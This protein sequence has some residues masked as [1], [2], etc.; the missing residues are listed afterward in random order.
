MTTMQRTDTNEW[1]L[2]RQYAQEGSQTAFRAIVD[3]YAALVYSTCL[4]ELG[5]R[6]VAEDA[7]QATF[8]VLATKATRLRPSGPLSAWLFSTARLVS[9]N[10]RRRE[11]AHQ[12]R[13]QAAMDDF[14]SNR[15]NEIPGGD[16]AWASIADN[17]HDA[18]DKLGTADR[19]ALLLRFFEQLS[20]RETADMLGVSEDA[21]KKRVSRALDKLRVRLTGRQVTVPV[22]VL[23]AL[24][25]ERAVN[26]APPT[27]MNALHAISYPTTLPPIGYSLPVNAHDYAQGAL[28]AMR[29]GTQKTAVTIA[30]ISAAALLTTGA[31]IYGFSHI[32]HGSRVYADVP[33]PPAGW[34][35]RCRHTAGKTYVYQMKQTVD[36]VTTLPSGQKTPSKLDE[37]MTF[38]NAVQ[39]VDPATGDATIRMSLSLDSITSGGRSVTLPPSTLAAITKPA[40]LHITPLGK[41][42]GAEGDSA[43]SVLAS[44]AGTESFPVKPVK[45]SD[46]WTSTMSITGSTYSVDSTLVRV[47]E[48]DGRKVAVVDMTLT[49]ISQTA[50]E[51][52]LQSQMGFDSAT[53]E[54]QYDI[55]N[56][57]QLVLHT[58]AV[59][60][61][62]TPTPQ[63]PAHTTAMTDQTSTL[64]SS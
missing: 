61:I 54:G 5:D 36:L 50:P 53:I 49:K 64:T 47:M 56:G 45:P 32:T 55:D 29:A 40:V 19:Q 34:L 22:M 11:V 6:Q 24:V 7:A 31:G 52:S 21:A 15:R 41:T 51:G 23:A 4:R 63:G 43:N 2:V 16:D 25:A 58:K 62:T 14:V 26:A 60:N 18:M 35:L 17:L 37:A 46:K 12:R 33:T 44:I 1:R 10:A 57:L 13:E 42:Y 48:K 3:R 30:A 39:A 28:H 38:T 8:L 27:C 59:S 20:M 9:K